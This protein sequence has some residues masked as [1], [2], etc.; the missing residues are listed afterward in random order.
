ME[1]QFKQ[2]DIVRLISGGPDMTI[3]GLHYDVLANEYVTDTYDCV[4]FAKGSAPDQEAHYGPFS[5][6][7]LVIVKERKV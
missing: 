7:E 6:N 3:H 1:R 4:W 2:G 5:V